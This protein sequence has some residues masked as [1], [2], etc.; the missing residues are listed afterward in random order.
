[1]TTQQRA[2][3]VALISPKGGVGKSLTC[4]TLAASLTKLGYTARIIDFDQT[5]TLYR[6]YTENP[7]VDLIEGL[8]IEKGPGTDIDID[9]LIKGLWNYAGHDFVF[10][11]L[12]GHM[13]RVALLLAT[14]ADITITPMGLDEPD[15]AETQKLSDEL[16]ALAPKMQ[17]QLI[18]RILIN[19]VPFGILPSHQAMTLDEIDKSDMVRFKNLLHLRPILSETWKTGTTP[20]YADQNRVPVKKAVEEI[21]LI[22]GELLAVF[23][24]QQEERVAA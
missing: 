14:A 13:S 17:K 20:H 4:L 9:A 19:K 18:H 21:D 3:I 10:V 6:W 5:E 16:K 12:A 8:T 23:Q 11:D 24:P 7:R 15:A 2:A 1:M 22:T